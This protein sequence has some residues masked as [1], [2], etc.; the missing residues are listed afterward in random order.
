MKIR[1]KGKLRRKAKKKIAKKD[2]GNKV[3]NKEFEKK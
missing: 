2:G 1:Q 3:T